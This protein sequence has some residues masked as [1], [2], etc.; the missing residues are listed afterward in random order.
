M[1]ALVDV[2][3]LEI[4]QIEMGGRGRDLG[5]RGSSKKIKETREGNGEG[6]RWR[7]RRSERRRGKEDRLRIKISWRKGAGEERRRKVGKDGEVGER[8]KFGG[9]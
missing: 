9:R 1:F 4:H 7:E 5:E 3:L 6:R 2:R 8:G